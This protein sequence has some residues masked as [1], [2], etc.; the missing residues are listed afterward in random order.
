MG[1][2]VKL[3]AALP[4]CG[5]LVNVTTRD[6]D[7]IARTHLYEPVPDSGTEL[8]AQSLKDWLRVVRQCDGL[9]VPRAEVH[10]D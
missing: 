5:V 4:V 2:V 6:E 10:R 3:I 1:G 9:A 7:G 8:D